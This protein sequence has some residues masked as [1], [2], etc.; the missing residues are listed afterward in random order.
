MRRSLSCLGFVS[1]VVACGGTGG[2]DTT[3]TDTGAGGAQATGGTSAGGKAGASPKGGAAGSAGKATGG[4]STVGGSGGASATGGAAGKASAGAG[5]ASAGASGAAGKGGS[6]G[7]SGGASGAAGAAGSAGGAPCAKGTIVC[8]GFSSE[9]CDGKGGFTDMKSC[10]TGCVP[11]IGCVA[12]VP[13]TGSCN[14]NVAQV[15]KLDGSGYTTQTCDADI[16]VTC[17]PKTFQCTGPCAPNQLQSSYIGCEYWPTTVANLVWDVF[18]FAVAV[19]NPAGAQPA[20][21]K[22]TRGATV[23]ATVTV[24]PGGLQIIK[25]PWVPEI[26]GGQAGPDGSVSGDIGTVMAPGGAY[27]LRST[28]PVSVYQ[29]N[30]LDY[31]L[32]PSDP[33]YASCPGLQ[34]FAGCFSYSNDA[35]LLLPTNALTGNYVVFTY[36]SWSAANLADYAAITATADGT[37]VTFTSSTTLQPGGGIGALG[38]GQSATVTMNAGDV[39]QIMSVPNGGDISGSIVKADKPV[40]VIAGLP[41]VYIPDGMGA[42]DHIEESI[43]PVETLGSEYLMTAPQPVGGNPTYELR[44]HGIDAGTV[45]TVDPAIGGMGTVNLGAGQTASFTVTGDY[46]LT[47]NKHFYVSQYMVGQSVAGIGDP[48]QS[49]GVPVGQYRSDYTFLAP[50]SYDANY[51]NITTGKGVMITLDGAP[52]PAASFKA[53]GA[54]PYGVATLPLSNSQSHVVKAIGGTAGIIVYG[55]GQ[56]TS[57]M[58]PGGLNLEKL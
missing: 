14:G 27:R 11:G 34:S 6:A 22:V 52:V 32:D 30:A 16:G 28:T 51:V 42:C 9:V 56:F 33:K 53:I 19:A 25:L 31:K 55:Y 21:V 49:N 12:C 40:Q 39:L 18:D 47:G 58:Y 4:A 45:V 41:C 38:A 20:N 46:H 8:S 26:K 2:T 36:P 43:L 3:A 29:F 50:N 10:P 17:D 1:L 48:S 24:A 7:A 57:Y 44:I 13:G 15:C 5:G 23:V 37:K 54:S 35:S